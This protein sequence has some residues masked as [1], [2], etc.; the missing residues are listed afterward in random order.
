DWADDV[1][2]S[3]HDYEDGVHARHIDPAALDA[4]AVVEAAEG[5]YLPGTDH[6]LLR[7]AWATLIAEPW[8]VTSYDGGP[9]D[10]AA[11]KRMTSELIGRFCSAAIRATRAVA[12]D[13]PLTRYAADLVVPEV[14]RVQ[15]ALL[16]AVAL[17]LVMREP[18][19]VAQ[20]ERQRGTL[21]LLAER[22]LARE[23]TDLEPLLRPAWAASR[24]DADRLRV[25]VDQIAMLTDASAQHLLARIR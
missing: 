15:S 23:G 16:K 17:D 19:R 13:G 24:T 6:D 12:G 7:A 9:A 3:V 18:V 11:L 4:D 8:W 20:Q 14:V 25:V 10:T 1:A 22:L 5:S 2:Y 21:H